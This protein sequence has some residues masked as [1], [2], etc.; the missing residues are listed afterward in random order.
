MGRGICGNIKKAKIFPNIL[1]LMLD[2]IVK[3]A[4]KYI[5]IQKKAI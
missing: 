1:R 3:R 2:L 5:I 4:T